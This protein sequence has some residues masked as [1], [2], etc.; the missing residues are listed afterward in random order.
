M[1]DIAG[2]EHAGCEADERGE[3]DEDVVEVIHQQIRGWLRAAEEQRDR[4]EEGQERRDHI[5]RRRQPVPRQRHQQRRRQRW[6]YENGSDRLEQ[7]RH[8]RPPRKRARGSKSTV[9]KRSRMRNRKMPITM[10]AMRIEK[11]MLI[12]TT[13]GMPLAPVAASTRPFSSDMKPTI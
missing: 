12:S 3:H 6:N 11:A 5:E 13:S 9:S 2:A 7:S 10:K 1:A 4:G 8:P